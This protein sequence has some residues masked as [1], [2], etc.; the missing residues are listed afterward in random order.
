MIFLGFDFFLFVNEPFGGH[1]II[2]GNFS[3]AIGCV[4]IVV[5]IGLVS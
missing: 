2:E 4:S 3:W 5:M 1:T